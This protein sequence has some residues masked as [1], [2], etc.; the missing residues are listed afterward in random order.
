MFI[1]F[2]FP[3]EKIAEMDDFTFAMR[4]NEAAYMLENVIMQKQLSLA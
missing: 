4:A 2:V 1:R 3:H